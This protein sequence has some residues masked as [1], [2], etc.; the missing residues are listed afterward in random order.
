MITHPVCSHIGRGHSTSDP[1]C[2]DYHAPRLSDVALML[3]TTTNMAD[4]ARGDLSRLQ[5]PATTSIWAHVDLVRAQRH[6][7]EA[8]ILI[9]KVADQLETEQEVAR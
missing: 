8:S 5:L 4:L 3:D 7:R 9:D 6:L 1:N 2:A